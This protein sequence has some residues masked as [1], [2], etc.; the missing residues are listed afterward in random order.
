PRGSAGAGPPAGVLG[1]DPRRGARAVARGRHPQ[2]RAARR[3]RVQLVLQARLAPLLP[4]VVRRHPAVGAHALSADRAAA[5][6]DTDGARR[7]VR[8]PRAA[9]PPGAAPRSIRGVAPL[10]PRTED[11]ERGY[12]SDLR[13]WH[14]VLLARRRGRAVRRDVHPPGG[15]PD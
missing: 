4:E 8:A 2:A 15:E 1:G 9:K 5:R 3:P 12:V 10:P 7:D 11:P 6:R 13:R 14:A